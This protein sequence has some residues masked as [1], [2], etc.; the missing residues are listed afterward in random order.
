[1]E[2][3]LKWK[4]GGMTSPG[5]TGEVEI[6][7]L[8]SQVMEKQSVSEARRVG[9]CGGM[10]PLQDNQAGKIRDKMLDRKTTSKIWSC[11]E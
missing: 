11:S 7:A 10:P 1:M 8:A 6:N 5:H 2:D 9:E 4:A 3:L